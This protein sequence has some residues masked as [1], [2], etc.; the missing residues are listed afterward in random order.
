MQN[1]I[2]QVWIPYYEWEDYLNGMWNKSVNNEPELLAKA[3]EFTSNHILYGS[4]MIR[5]ID[6]WPK[7]MINS[8]TNKSINQKAFV[9]HCAVSFELGI[10]EYITRKAWKELTDKQRVLADNEALKAILIWRKK[11]LTTLKNGNQNVT[12]KEYQTQ[13]L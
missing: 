10:P 1:Q 7:T 13:L 11:Y 2:K 8:L 5:V 4:A 12:Q 6:A 3:I 9:G